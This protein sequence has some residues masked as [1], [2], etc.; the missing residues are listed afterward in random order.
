MVQ[1]SIDEVIAESGQ[2]PEAETLLDYFAVSASM[3]QGTPSPVNLREAAAKAALNRQSTQDGSSVGP[4][5]SQAQ[6]AEPRTATP[7][8]GADA[9]RQAVHDFNHQLL[10]IDDRLHNSPAAMVAGAELLEKLVSDVIK[11]KGK[12]PK[13]HTKPLTV[14]EALFIKRA[15]N[16]KAVWRAAIALGFR[17]Q[18]HEFEPF[19]VF[20][21]KFED[22]S[23]DEQRFLEN[24]LRMIEKAKEGFLR[25]LKERNDEGRARKLHADEQ[26]QA[27]LALIREDQEE[28][29]ASAARRKA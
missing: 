8:K 10:A 20:Y 15:H 27:A 3:S 29:R 28:R 7:L 18:T 12:S 19:L 17:E 4:A 11:H 5:H 13:D 24:A 21:H 6:I 25:H 9:V 23:A 26:R 14:K 22:G 16:I 2:A 1:N